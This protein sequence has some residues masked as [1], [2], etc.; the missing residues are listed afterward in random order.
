MRVFLTGATGFVG[1]AILPELLAA[2]HQ[3]LGYARSD[4]AA[5]KLT[6][7]GAEVQRG[8]LTDLASL[9]AGARA[10]DAVIHTAFIHDFSKFMENVEIDR[11]ATIAFVEALA[12]TGKTLITT[13]G[14]AFLPPGRVATE[15][16]VPVSPD[17]PRA[18]AEEMVIAAA[19]Q[20]IRSAVVRLS[21]SVHGAGDHGFVPRL[22]DFAREKGFAAYVGE[23]ANVWPGVHRLD[24]G[25]LYRLVLEHAAGGLRWHGVAEEGVPFRDIATAI[26]QGLNIPVRSVSGAEAEAYFTWFLRFASMDVPSSSAATRKLLGWQPKNPGLLADISTA[27]YF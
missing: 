21:P 1:S 26:G 6:A 19:A 8:E 12:G 9:T 2:G 17:M 18:A 7:L 23:G 20:G 15:A 5:A 22:I 4:D 14:L 13:S 24:A 11:L 10:S 27:G 25:A 3:V 16:D